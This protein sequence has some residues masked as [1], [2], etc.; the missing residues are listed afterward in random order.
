MQG[1]LGI[2]AHSSN[3]VP[4]L[5]NAGV[6][7]SPIADSLAITMYIASRYPSL[8]PAHRKE[9]ICRLLHDLHA[10][11]Y[12]SLSFAGKPQVPASAKDAIIKQIED[13]ATSQR[14]R[15]AL[16]YKLTM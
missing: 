14:Y 15:D 16:V 10:V 5:A 12:F 1:A 3:Q 6:L 13:P 11:N 9:E 7:P 4:V 2:T 8:L